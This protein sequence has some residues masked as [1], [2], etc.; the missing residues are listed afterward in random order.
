MGREIV[1]GAEAAEHEIGVR[2]GERRAERT[3][4]DDH[5]AHRAAH[6]LHGAVRP[7]G[8]LD[9]GAGVICTISTDDPAMF[10][11]DLSTEY[12]AATSLGFEPR[13][14]YD[15]G[16]EGALC[17]EDTRARLRNI[18]DEFDWNAVRAAEVEVP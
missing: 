9:V 16:V 13:S 15:A 11:T 18:A 7:D 1:A 3:V 4:A 5:E 12:A 14:F 6:L 10:G 2:A 17:D 8:E